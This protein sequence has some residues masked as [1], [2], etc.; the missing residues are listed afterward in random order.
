MNGAPE[1]SED[2]ASALAHLRTMTHGRIF[3]EAISLY[4]KNVRLFVTIGA[5]VLIPYIAIVVVL[6]AL[7]VGSD[8]KIIDAIATTLYDRGLL[9]L[10]PV[11]L[12][13]DLVA[14]GLALA[15]IIFFCIIEP[16]AA[17]ALSVAV[18][19]RYAS[20]PTTVRQAYRTVLPRSGRLMLTMIW[21]LLRLVPLVAACVILIGIPLVCYF[22]VAWFF[23]V[24]IMVLEDRFGPAS[25]RSW[26]LVKG[27]WW[28]TCAFVAIIALL[29]ILTIV[30]VAIG[31]TVITA[32]LGITDPQPQ[33]QILII[34]VVLAVTLVLPAKVGATTLYYYALKQRK[35]EM[36][37]EAATS[38]VLPK[39]R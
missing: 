21:A 33:A 14:V 37:V 22:L 7:L 34:M 36:I 13:Y 10:D 17:S 2:T 35:E 12:Y 29:F 8:S 4:T 16:V 30:M 20:R 18:A 27:E 23:I 9:S 32:I 1:Q 25:K 6:A 19:Q 3:E 39:R 38:D 5:V 28:R 31:T 11:N 26:D 24:P 15:I